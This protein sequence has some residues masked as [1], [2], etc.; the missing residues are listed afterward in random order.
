MSELAQLTSAA[1]E[2]TALLAKADVPFPAKFQ[3]QCETNCINETMDGV[4]HG[5]FVNYLPEKLAKSTGM[6]QAAL[7]VL[8]KQLRDALKRAEQAGC[9]AGVCSGNRKTRLQRYL[10]DCC[11]FEVEL[12]KFMSTFANAICKALVDALRKIKRLESELGRRGVLA[13]VVVSEP[14]EPLDDVALLC[15]EGHKFRYG[16]SVS[17]SPMKAFDL[18]VLAARRGS[19]EGMTCAGALLEEGLVDAMR[20]SL[21]PDGQTNDVHMMLSPSPKREFPGEGMT[22]SGGDPRARMDKRVEEA[23]RD[24]IDPLTKKRRMFEARCWYEKAADLDCPDAIYRV[25][26]LIE[27]GFADFPKDPLNAA[28]L[29][30]RA[31]R[32]GHAEAQV[33]L[34]Y[35]YEM[36][37][38][39]HYPQGLRKAYEWYNKA[40]EQRNARA[41]NN[42]GSLLYSGKGCNRDTE[43][44]AELFKI[45][46]EQGHANAHHNLGVCYE[47]GVGVHAEDTDAAAKLYEAAARRGHV[48]AS[49]ALGILLYKLATNAQASKD[50]FV[51]AAKW[52]RR[53]ADE[54]HGEA[55]FYLAQMHECGI[56]VSRDLL[57]AYALYSRA[58]E[59]DIV[60]AHTRIGN[61]LFCGGAGLGVANPKKATEH[62]NKAAQQSND[63]EAWN[64]LG[65]CHEQGAADEAGRPDY[66]RAVECFEKAQAGGSTDASVNLGRLLEQ[67]IGTGRDVSRALLLYEEAAAKGNINA[68]TIVNKRRRQRHLAEHPAAYS[69][70]QQSEPAGAAPGMTTTTSSFQF[71]HVA[72]AGKTTATGGIYLQHDAQNLRLPLLASSASPQQR[73]P[74]VLSSSPPRH[75]AATTTTTTFT[76]FASPTKSSTIHRGPPSPS[77]FTDGAKQEGG[78]SPDMDVVHEGRVVRGGGLEAR[79]PGASPTAAVTELHTTEYPTPGFGSLGSG[80]Q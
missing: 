28:K 53:A 4:D 18:Y 56:G 63:P 42:L 52:L 39:P 50:R 30:E 76:R 41:L 5:L 66:V 45:A 78:D 14:Q 62:F 10:R 69:Y 23:V 47:T 36:G 29:Y 46:A 73:H 80:A 19:P 13:P 15:I 27:R 55:L 72:T 65:L 1:A 26:R 54:G 71:P 22:R 8:I 48:K 57:Q 68:R 40:A 59:K 43:R 75:N 12:L 32:M 49:A 74:T 25:A 7:G 33:D 21:D 9:C 58:A 31:A 51:E 6:L 70:T 60:R 79:R 37:L 64:N 17:C 67:G 38:P 20:P 16:H 11:G 44:A 24:K 77:P 61:L 3:I 34:G 2:L 35:T